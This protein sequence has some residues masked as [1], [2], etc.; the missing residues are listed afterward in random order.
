MTDVAVIPQA[1]VILPY[2]DGKILMQLRDDKE[3][4]VFPGR[5]GF[6]SGAV[7]LGETPLECAYREFHEE[8]DCVVDK[9]Y[10]LGI[11]TAEVPFE[12]VLHSFYCYLPCAVEA[13]VLLEGY[14]FGL[15]SLHE[16]STQQLYSTK[17]GYCYPVISHA[18]IFEIANRCFTRLQEKGLK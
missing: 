12:I 1:A 17:A 16:I 6:F 2:R 11:D 14:D 18:I 5:W 7:E 3:G 10:P 8:L 15:F 9:M 4:I 13:I